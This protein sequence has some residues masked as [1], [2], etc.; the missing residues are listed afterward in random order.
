ML[1]LQIIVVA[2]VLI[3]LSGFPALLFSNKTRTGQLFTTSLLTTGSI[4]GLFGIGLFYKI[5]KTASFSHSWALPIG[6]FSVELDSI[7]SIFLIMVF[8]IPMFGSLYGLGYW[9]QTEHPENGRKLGIFY[10]LLA[11]AMA[12]VVIARDGVLFL[13]VWEIMA[14]AAFFAASI[15]DENPEVRQAGWVYLIATHIGTLFLIALFALWYQIT[16]SF[17]LVSVKTVSSTGAAALFLLALI[18]FGFKAGIMPLHVWLPGAHA[19]APSHVSAVMS[20]VMLKMGIYGIIRMTSLLPVTESWWGGT[21]LLVGA[22]SG[23]AGIAYAIAQHDIKKILAY[24]SIENIGIICLGIGLGLLGRSYHRT[25]WIMLGFGGAMIHVLNHSF[26]KSLLFFNAGSIIHATHTRQ[27]DKM[28]GLSKIMPVSMVLFIIGSVAISALPPLN[29]FISEWL[30]YLGLFRTIFNES[31]NSFSVAALGTVALAMIGPLAIACFV[32]LIGAVFLG[33]KKSSSTVHTVKTPQSMNIPMI[34][35]ASICVFI[36]I[37]P[38]PVVSV[39]EDGVNILSGNLTTMQ[40]VS[41]LISFS[42]ISIIGIAL[43]VLFG[44]VMILFRLKKKF[45]NNKM[46]GTWDCGYACPT[47]RMQYTGSSFGDSIVKL[48]SFIIWPVERRPEIAGNFPKKSGFKSIISDTVLDKII[49]PVFRFAGKYLPM[50][51]FFQKGLTHS[52]VLY[53]LAVIIILLILG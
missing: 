28:G 31:G 39:I 20:G 21:V 48:F 53:I 25:D 38:V 16:G 50:V 51:R 19:N 5:G 41:Q 32:R 49:M 45:A 22:L 23:I 33:N 29:G 9:K 7:S 42:W 12:F 13:I 10:G 35:L 52:Y 18:G 6:M 43:I 26:F 8:L 2:I 34:V 36:G 3:G 46:Y 1:S 47:S 17:A 11:G 24:S 44:I 4:S 37:Y 40:T 27:I 15:D 30:I 14:L